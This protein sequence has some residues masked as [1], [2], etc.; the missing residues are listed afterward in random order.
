MMATVITDFSTR[1]SRFKAGDPVS[2]RADLSPYT[3]DDLVKLGH[4]EK[5][6]VSKG[7]TIPSNSPE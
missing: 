2:P 4:I 6:P 5:L 7:K 1:S 3:F